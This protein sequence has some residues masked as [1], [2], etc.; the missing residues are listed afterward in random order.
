MSK[1]RN[2][3]FYDWFMKIVEQNTGV[4]GKRIC[5]D[6][7][8]DDNRYMEWRSIVYRALYT[9]FNMTTADIGSIFGVSPLTASK[10]IN[11]MDIP[12][13]TPSHR[14]LYNKIIDNILK[15]FGELD[16]LRTV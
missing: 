5:S 11:A 2:V 14:Y 1:I 12:Q 13:Y 15:R 4:L 3:S 7:L 9:E 16:E 6:R 8:P 10:A